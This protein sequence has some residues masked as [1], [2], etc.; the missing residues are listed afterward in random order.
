MATLTAT[1]NVAG[2][3][4]NLVL[5]AGFVTTP[6]TIRRLDAAGNVFLVRNG[7]PGTTNASGT[8]LGQDYEI[9]LD[10]EC[11]YT[12]QSGAS[13]TTS[14]TVY[15]TAT[16]PWLGHPGKPIMN[17]QP[18]VREFRFGSL[19]ARS[20]AQAVIGRKLPIGQALKRGSYTGELELLVQNA[21][22]VKLEVM[23]ED[24]Q[25]LLYRA[26]ATWTNQGTRYLQV[27][28]VQINNLMRVG[29]NARFYVTLPWTEVE[30]PALLAQAGAGFQ[31][32]SVKATYGDWRAVI[33]SNPTWF[34]VIDG[35]P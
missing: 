15:L 3:Y 34:D 16:T 17:F 13:L 24:G 1:P 11:Y 14:S 12:A 35:V 5:S 33:G 21:D 18:V 23:L 30:R 26:P 7:D 10:K 9:P 31:W 20:T 19:P 8:W 32:A 27:G 4:V 28:D 22:F 29:K 25:V 6:Y 2:G